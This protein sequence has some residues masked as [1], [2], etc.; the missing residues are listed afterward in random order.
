MHCTRHRAAASSTAAQMLA[1]LSMLWCQ[2]LQ[3][4]LWAATGP[5]FVS[6]L[7]LWAQLSKLASELDGM[8][9]FKHGPKLRFILYT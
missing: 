2:Q 1:A 8:P 4:G 3:G 6:R 5:L 9:N 7:Q